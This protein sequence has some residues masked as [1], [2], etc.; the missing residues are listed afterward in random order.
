MLASWEFEQ[1]SLAHGSFISTGGKQAFLEGSYA[2]VDDIV[3]AK[4]AAAAAGASGGLAGTGA[5]VFTAA[6]VLTTAVGIGV[7]GILKARQQ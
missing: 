4:Q 7:A 5:A 2:F 3:K 6:A 1:V